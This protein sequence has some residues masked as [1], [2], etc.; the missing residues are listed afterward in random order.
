MIPPL[1]PLRLKKDRDMF[2]RLFVLH[3]GNIPAP[4][5]QDWEPENLTVL[6]TDQRADEPRL[7]RV[8]IDGTWR[9]N[10]HYD[11]FCCE[12]EPLVY[13]GWTVDGE[14]FF[15]WKC[16]V[17]GNESMTMYPGFRSPKPPSRFGGSQKHSTARRRERS[18]Y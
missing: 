2:E 10:R 9:A 3:A 13:I 1:F 18:G 12:P 4:Y 17:C 11:T 16:P 8:E 5:A 15:R 14:W 6:A 7:C